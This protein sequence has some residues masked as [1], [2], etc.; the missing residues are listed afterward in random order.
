MR[1]ANG[2]SKRINWKVGVKR[3]N[4]DRKLL[5]LKWFEMRAVE[6]GEIMIEDVDLLEE[7]RKSK[8]KKNKVIK[9]VNKIK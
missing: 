9:I 4:E 6:R 8:A 7:I 2:L 3:D 5:K 1:K